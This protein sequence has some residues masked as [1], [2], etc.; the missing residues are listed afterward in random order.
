MPFAPTDEPTLGPPLLQGILKSKGIK[1]SIFYANKIFAKECNKIFAEGSD[2]H[3]PAVCSDDIYRFIVQEG[4]TKDLG[5][6]FFARQT[7][8]LDDSG[9]YLSPF[10]DKETQD[11]LLKCRDRFE[12]VTLE[13][14]NRDWNQYDLIGFSCT[15]TQIVPSLCLAKAIKHRFPK[16]EIIFGGGEMAEDPASQIILHCP[17]VDK[18]FVGDGEHSL[19]YYIETGKTDVEGI[20]QK[21]GD[22]IQ[23]MGESRLSSN[24]LKESPDPIYDDFYDDNETTK[25]GVAITGRGCM[26]NKC[27]FCV[28]TDYKPYRKTSVDR[29][30]EHVSN[31]VKH[32]N[33]EDVLF[34]DP[35]LPPEIFG[36]LPKI[37]GRYELC[38]SSLTFKY[39]HLPYLKGGRITFGIE[40]FHPEILKLLNKKQSI[41]NCISILKWL[42]YY[43]VAVSWMFLFGAIGEKG[44]WY[45][46][47][48]PLL[49]HLTHLPPP[50]S[51]HPIM[52]IR[53]S[54][55]R[56]AFKHKP[57]PSYRYIYPERFDY[58]KIARNFELV[59]KELILNKITNWKHIQPV[60][61]FTHYWKCKFFTTSLARYES[62]VIDERY[63]NPIRINVNPNEIAILSDCDKPAKEKLIEETYSKKDI[64]SL[65]ESHLLLKM[66]KKYLSL[67]EPSGHNIM[68]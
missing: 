5:N 10:F 39:E 27:S 38:I 53:T 23:F 41:I 9:K 40:S 60:V 13:L 46:E 3:L 12:K 17:W 16:I 25:K 67:V 8:Q 18:V 68:V 45:D 15:F 35:I 43:G 61:D 11:M 31:M 59:D 55:M 42:K 51:A 28:F 66:E 62:V 47:M 6:W 52:A 20:M 33:L 49:R 19:P 24:L 63:D 22:E 65:L 36:K 37:P 2:C 44:E 4:T 57:L 50:E 34:Y 32:H 64:D 58:E 48:L 56:K 21:N 29:T 30:L 1:S 7:F 54:Q 14:A 26:Y